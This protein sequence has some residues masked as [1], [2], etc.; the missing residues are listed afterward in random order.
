VGAALA[1]KR[2][3]SGQVA[4]AFFGDGA[5]NI[6]A[7]HEAMNLA[8][9]W[10]VPCVFV[11]ENNRY[12]QSTPVEYSTAGEVWRRAAGYG[13]PGE[14]VDGQD[15]FA[16]HAAA[17]R[18]VERARG[19]A[20]PS[21]IEARTYRYYGHSYG[22]DPHRYRLDEE[23]RAARARDCLDGFRAAVLAAGTMTAAE[24]AAIDAKVAAL[25]DE[26]VAFAEAGAMPDPREVATQVYA[27]E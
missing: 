21:L 7:T 14:W 5:A 11:C 4:V 3:E 19:G 18:A 8:A 10:Q 23:E 26:A 24:L 12:A 15:V 9:V 25:I 16:V 2:R 27:G 17:A 20:G 1:A 6:G 13:M 22:D